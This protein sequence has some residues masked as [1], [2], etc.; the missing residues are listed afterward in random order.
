MEKFWRRV[1]S[2]HE[3][4]S[5]GWKGDVLVLGVIIVWM[6][7]TEML[8]LTLPGVMVLYFALVTFW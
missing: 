8:M 7:L 6:A 2:T 5:D 1:W 3:W 4:M